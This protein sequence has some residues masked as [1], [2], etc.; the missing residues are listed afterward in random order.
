MGH[1]VAA[2]AAWHVWWRRCGLLLGFWGFCCVLGLLLFV[3]FCWV[4]GWCGGYDSGVQERNRWWPGF[5]F[6][7]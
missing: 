1:M 4:L 7:I 6:V 5:G 3:G 2:A